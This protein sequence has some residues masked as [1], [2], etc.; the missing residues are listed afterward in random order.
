MQKWATILQDPQIHLLCCPSLYYLPFV[1][2]SSFHTSQKADISHPLHSFIVHR[3]GI[4]AGDIITHI[5]D[6]EVKS[7]N[8]IYNLVQAK[9]ELTAT[10]VRGPTAEVMKVKVIPEELQ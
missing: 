7:A 6:K 8:D 9:Q 5:N 4:K 10:I 2:H 3:A 1:E